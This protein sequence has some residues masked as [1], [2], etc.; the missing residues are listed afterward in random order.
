MTI[1]LPST[2]RVFGKGAGRA[3]GGVY[4]R[5]IFG[6]YI[7]SESS[8]YD[9]LSSGFALTMG[10]DTEG[11]GDPVVLSIEVISPVLK[12]SGRVVCST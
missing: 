2:W 7:D 1:Y 9:W 8:S 3:T 11:R 5:R 6:L 12:K 4:D 10:I